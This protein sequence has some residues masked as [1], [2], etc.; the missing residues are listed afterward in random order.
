MSKPTGTEASC[1]FPFSRPTQRH[2]GALLHL[3]RAGGARQPAVDRGPRAYEQAGRISAVLATDNNVLRYSEGRMKRDGYN[4]HNNIH[5]IT[6]VKCCNLYSLLG[7]CESDCGT[8]QHDHIGHTV[9]DS[10]RDCHAGGDHL[11]HL[12]RSAQRYRLPPE[13][14]SLRDPRHDSVMS[15]R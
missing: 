14:E 13:G 6:R 5:G 2:G 9:A 7:V 4:G 15:N 3:R 10:E 1:C 8:L 12:L 11:P